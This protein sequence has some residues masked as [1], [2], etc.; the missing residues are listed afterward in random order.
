M[1]RS[2]T[3]VKNKHEKNHAP[4]DG[5]QGIRNTVKGRD[6]QYQSHNNKLYTIYALYDIFCGHKRTE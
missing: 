3:R 1:G 5:L 4:S 6:T 2:A